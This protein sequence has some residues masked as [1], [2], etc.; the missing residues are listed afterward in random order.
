MLLGIK[1]FTSALS[2][3]EISICFFSGYHKG[4]E[5]HRLRAVLHISSYRK[6]FRKLIFL[7]TCLM[8]K[9]QRT[10]LVRHLEWD[11]WSPDGLE[12][13]LEIPIFQYTEL[14]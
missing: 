5:I 11:R 9:I 10:S 2:W 4:S 1:T 3:V 13:L 6:H 8:F 7:W 12:K 14:M